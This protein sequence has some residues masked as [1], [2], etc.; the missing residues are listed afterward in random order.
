MGLW[1]FYLGFAGLLGTFLGGYLCDK[2][3]LRDQRWYLWLPAGA[4]ILAI[5]FSVFVYFWPVH[6]QALI[7]VNI[8][9]VLGLFYIAPSFALTQRMVG[10]RMR[11]LAASILLFITNL[12]G[13]GLCPQITGILSDVINSYTDLGV[14]SLR[15]AMVSVLVFNVVSTIFYLF[16][17]K[18]L[19][20]DLAQP[21]D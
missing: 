17:S 12:I 1:L 11:A 16:A 6:V 9:I 4:T 3:A 13:L 7:V 15:W 21:T 8:P 14:D 2:P 5:P 20:E 18:Y 10:I 19:R